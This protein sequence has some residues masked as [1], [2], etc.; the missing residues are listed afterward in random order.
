[1]PTTVPAKRRRPASKSTNGDAAVG[2]FNAVYDEIR[3]RIIVGSLKG[4]EVLVEQDLA[5]TLGVSRTPIREAL[6]KLAAEGLVNLEHRRRARVA[7]IEM[8]DVEDVYLLRSLLETLA[9]ERAAL[10]INDAQ[11]ALLQANSD[12]LEKLVPVWEWQ[13]VDQFRRIN[14]EFHLA[15]LEAANSR[16]LETALRPIIDLPLVLI[17]R[18]QSFS[19]HEL[20]RTCRQHRDLIDALRAHDSA[21]A[22]ALMRAHVLSAHH[23][24]GES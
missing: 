7:T 1:M 4:G 23:V 2:T 11:I 24:G 12:E 10:H 21:W 20:E 17:A 13:L 16:W 19:R 3:A 18:Y 14:T 15:I 5:A 6:R 22:G 8:R 9:A